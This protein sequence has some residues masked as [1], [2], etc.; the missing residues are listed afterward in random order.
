MASIS[1]KSF[2]EKAGR[3]KFLTLQERLDRVNVRPAAQSA[4]ITGGTDDDT[5]WTHFKET[6]DRWRDL[7]LSSGFRIFFSSL[8]PLSLSLPVLYFNRK[9]VLKKLCDEIRSTGTKSIPALCELTAALARDLG[10]AEFM[11][12]FGEVVATFSAVLHA[13][14]GRAGESVFWDPT[15]VVRPVFDAVGRISRLF[16]RWMIKN[17]KGTFESLSLLLNSDD[18][19]LRMLT[20]E[21][22]I[23]YLLRKCRDREEISP[24]LELVFQSPAAALCI[25]EGMRGAKSK[26]TFIAPTLLEVALDISTENLDRFSTLWNAMNKLAGH[27]QSKPDASPITKVLVAS[28]TSALS[29]AR[30]DASMSLGTLPLRLYLVRQWL[31]YRTGKLVTMEESDSFVKRLELYLREYGGSSVEPA[32][33]VVEALGALLRRHVAMYLLSARTVSAAVAEERISWKL[34]YRFAYLTREFMPLDP[35][36]G[37]ALESAKHHSNALVEEVTAINGK[38]DGQPWKAPIHIL[39]SILQGRSDTDSMVSGSSRDWT[40]VVQKAIQSGDQEQVKSALEVCCFVSLVNGRE[41]LSKA[42]VEKDSTDVKAI[43]LKAMARQGHSDDE[44]LCKSALELLRSEPSNSNVLEACICFSI[45]RYIEAEDVLTLVYLNM[46]NDDRGVLLSTL[47]LLMNNYQDDRKILFELCYELETSEIGPAAIDNTKHLVSRLQMLV[48]RGLDPR[49]LEFL[50]CFSLA[51]MKSRFTPP[52]KEASA[53]WCKCYSKLPGESW[54]HMEP[55]LN[56]SLQSKLSGGQLSGHGQGET[57]AGNDGPDSISMKTNSISTTARKRKTMVDVPSEP[58]KTKV[59]QK[60]SA[61]LVIEFQVL[62]TQ[63]ETVSYWET[64]PQEAKGGTEALA[65]HLQLLKTL[66]GDCTAL[67]DHSRH[68]LRE[69]FVPSSAMGTSLQDLLRISFFCKTCGKAWRTSD[70]QA[71]RNGRSWT[72]AS[73]PRFDLAYDEENIGRI[74]DVGGPCIPR[75]PLAT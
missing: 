55:L 21:S 49:E 12:S 39:R 28:T 59:E 38:R 61:P 67:K 35:L 57:N 58:K 27:V 48:D 16:A 56:K 6:L 5:S 44:Q 17:A 1:V 26:L 69:V 9:K 11:P 7:D 4:V 8:Q 10:A 3:Y 46:L 31:T 25:F 41:V 20:A 51:T 45:S 32:I 18:E 50:A 23:G 24:V 29:S 43:S 36:L 60:D 47:R 40:S 70:M 71:I 34:G 52:W 74:A 15:N 75:L 64:V 14:S 37:V 53:L 72:G 30:C 2:D 42:V 73:H 68:F 63:I 66:D 65:L 33:Y 13:P 62:G 22:S 54:R 19:R